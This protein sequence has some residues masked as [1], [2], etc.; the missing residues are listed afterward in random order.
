[1]TSMTNC[2]QSKLTSKAICHC[3]AVVIEFSGAPEKV[4]EC[5]C[6]ICRRLGALWVYRALEEV[7]LIYAEGA[8]STYSW[9]DKTLEFHRCKV[10]GCT[11][12][13]LPL[14]EKYTVMGINARMIDGLRPSDV[15]ISHEEFGGDGCFWS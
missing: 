2:D 11:T 6:S 13:W 14:N 1:M 4:A 5:N 15:E 9:G 8:T 10:C 7:S 12:H 3:G